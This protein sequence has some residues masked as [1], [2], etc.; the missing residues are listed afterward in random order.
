MSYARDSYF[1][2]DIKNA[3]KTRFEE[4]G[5][6]VPME[7]IEMALA[8]LFDG[9]AIH[10]W[11]R[12]DVY[13]LARGASWP[14]SKEAADEILSNVERHIDAELGI[15]WMTIDI[16]MSDFYGSLDWAALKKDEQ[17]NYQGCFLLEI[18]YE[19]SH[20]QPPESG[21]LLKKATLS[22]AIHDAKEIMTIS[23]MPVKLYSLSC[24]EE[25]SLDQDWL[26]KN[27]H[28]L[29]TFYSKEGGSVGIG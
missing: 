23:G 3:L 20:K 27:A 21:K 9:V 16:A 17:E 5:H 11:S 8:D 7:A 2:A 14:T 18:M 13:K 25:P 22:T 29:L 28:E 15:T 6:D 19:N 10:V 4:D 26:E 12:E 24:K 1:Y